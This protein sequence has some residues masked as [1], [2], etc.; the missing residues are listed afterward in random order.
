M[1]NHTAVGGHFCQRKTLKPTI[2]D[3]TTGRREE[4]ETK[5]W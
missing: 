3:Q 5:A 2:D 1:S 4:N